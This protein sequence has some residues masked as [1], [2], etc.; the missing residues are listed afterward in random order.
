[1]RL[2]REHGLGA[3]RDMARYLGAQ[4]T[5]DGSPSVT[6]AKRSLVAKEAFYSMGRLW[7]RLESLSV[8]SEMFRAL[9]LNSMLWLNSKEIPTTS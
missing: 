2:A 3:V 4:V 7:K 1:M 6:V 9:V 8:K 5:H